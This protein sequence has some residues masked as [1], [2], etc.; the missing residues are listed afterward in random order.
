MGARKAPIRVDKKL[1]LS[2]GRTFE[3][4]TH[5]ERHIFGT[6]AG[7]TAKASALRFH[8][9]SKVSPIAIQGDGLAP[10]NASG[11]L[12]RSPKPVTLFWLQTGLACFLRYSV[13][14]TH[15]KTAAAI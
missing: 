10:V 6:F 2:K 15:E 9:D 14:G 3:Q 11:R 12:N 4:R 13:L 1:R 5:A 8:T 7:E